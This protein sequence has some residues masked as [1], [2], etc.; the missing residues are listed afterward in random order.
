MEN[1]NK[2]S[3][4]LSIIALVIAIFGVMA[5]C[6]GLGF[7]PSL[8]ALV[9]SIVA[10]SRSKQK[11]GL[12]IAGLVCSIVGLM[13][14][15][16]AAAALLDDSSDDNSGSSTTVSNTE[17]V[18]NQGEAE[19]ESE[20]E[21][22][23]QNPIYDQEIVFRDIPWG[24]SCTEV[25][26]IWGSM[27]NVAGDGYKT[28][29]SDDIILGD[30]QGIDF[31]YDDINIISTPYNGEVEVAGYTTSSVNFY[32]A[33]IPVDGVLTREEQ[34]SA[35]YGARYEFEAKNLEEMSK[36]L[37]QKLT[38]VYGEPIKTTEK[39]D[40]YDIK[41]T[42]TYW[43]GANDTVLVLKAQDTTNDTTDIFEDEI[44]ISYV[45]LK[46]D[47]MLQEASDISK[48]EALDKEAEAYGNDST[49]G[50]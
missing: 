26:N 22:E 30:Y 2:T 16:G 36:D 42:Y 40:L 43:Y 13:L 47:E 28:F 31:E 10:M 39:T 15:L 33:Y 3:N 12:A 6:M 48:Q 29:S 8:I 21:T 25:E 4:G 44:Y 11:R 41:Y 24:T 5:P 20:S 37:I 46:G 32:F 38:S 14:Y 19:I 1:E 7:L 34:D 23:P 18:S 45:W 27:V 49:G 35:L 17:I 9:L 50:L